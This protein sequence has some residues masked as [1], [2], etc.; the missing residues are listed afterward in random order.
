MSKQIFRKSLQVP[1]IL[2]LEVW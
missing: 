1:A 2:A